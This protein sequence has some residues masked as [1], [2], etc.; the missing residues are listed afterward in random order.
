MKGVSDMYNQSFG[1]IKFN[2]GWDINGKIMLWGKEYS[3]IITASAYFEEDCITAEQEKAF[4]IFKNNRND[5]ESKIELL[6][7]EYINKDIKDDFTSKT[8]SK[9]VIPKSFIFERNGGYA[10]L[11]DYI[12]CPE[13]GLAVQLAPKETV[14]TQDEYL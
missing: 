3:I 5:T 7:N 8:L 6:L 12:N 10:L 11:L 14:L 2:H 9:Y 13:N 1:E 4:D